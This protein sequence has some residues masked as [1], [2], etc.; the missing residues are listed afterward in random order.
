[1]SFIKICTVIILFTVNHL[2]VYALAY[3]G[4]ACTLLFSQN[5]DRSE[6]ETMIMHF[7]IIADVVNAELEMQKTQLAGVRDKFSSLDSRRVE[8]GEFNY[9][10]MKERLAYMIKSGERYLELLARLQVKVS[11]PVL[12]RALAQADP[13]RVNLAVVNQRFA[14]ITTPLKY[15]FDEL[16]VLRR[17]LLKPSP[18]DAL[19]HNIEIKEENIRLQ[20]N[21]VAELFRVS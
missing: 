4:T 7:E 14:A 18:S 16:N 6:S 2:P 5:Y 13:A 12:K 20:L 17:R 10:F 1:M 15:E 11:I 19:L 21:Q 3:A 8:L 9:E